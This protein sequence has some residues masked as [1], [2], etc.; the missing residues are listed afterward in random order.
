MIGMIY[1]FHVNIMKK[2]VIQSKFFYY[3]LN[4]KKD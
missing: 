2:N 4:N 3:L 1:S